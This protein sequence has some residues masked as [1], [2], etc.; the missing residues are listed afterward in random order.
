MIKKGTLIA[1]FSALLFTANV[2]AETRLVVGSTATVSPFYGYF[3]S[4]SNIINDNMP[5]YRATTIET[6]ASVENLVRMGRGQLDM[7]MVTTDLMGDAINGEGKFEGNPVD[8]RLLWVYFNI[9]QV[10]LARKDSEINGFQDLDGKSFGPGMRGSATEAA[11]QLVL[12]LF[13]V[14]PKYFHGSAQDQ[15]DAMKNREVVAWTASSMGHKISASQI[16]VGS[17][18]DLKPLS[19]TDE[20]IEIIKANVPQLSIETIP[21]GAGEGY[22]EFTTW[23]MGLGVAAMANMDEDTAYNIV[24]HVMENRT[25]QT[26][27]M[28][29]TADFDFIDLTLKFANT[30]LHPGAI[31][32]FEEQGYEVPAN[33]K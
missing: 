8:A 5:G 20:E 6:G 16:D 23:S 32:Y 19:L 7:G 24:K 15:M 28:P 1:A 4:I 2:S 27:A 29:R 10:T 30:P 3:V 11:T 26:N 25:P 22:P 9:P 12:D 13:D 33:L 31:K 21:A 14:K 17:F 18:I